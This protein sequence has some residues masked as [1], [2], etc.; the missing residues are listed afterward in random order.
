MIRQNRSNPCP[1][2]VLGWLAWYPEVDERGRPL[3]DVRQRATV[4]AHLVECEDC[5]EE[6]ELIRGAP[7]EPDLDLPDPDRMFA[8]ILARVAS[9]E[10]AGID[11]ETALPC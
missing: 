7:L 3:L 1:D 2:D 10:A 5:F 4:E 8:A 11:P 9:E 6:V